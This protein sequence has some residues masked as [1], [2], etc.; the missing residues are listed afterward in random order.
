[1]QLTAENYA[2]GFLVDEEL[3]GGVTEDPDH[4]GVFVA[5]VL[6][7]T[8]GEYLGYQPFQELGHALQAINQVE[9]SWSFDTVGGCG[10]CKDGSCGK[11]AC[12]KGGNC[13]K[14]P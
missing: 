6:R 7:H 8:T 10:G 4:K 12:S 5:F 3:M 14:K 1:M 11:G 9:R 2:K 13:C